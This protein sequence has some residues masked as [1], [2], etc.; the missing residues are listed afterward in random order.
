MTAYFTGDLHLGH[1]G[2]L[3]FAGRPWGTIEEHDAAIVENVNETVGRNDKLYIL[4]DFT[5]RF[6]ND[7]V[8][9]YLDAI[10]CKNRWLILGNH[11]KAG[12]LRAPGS[13][14]AVTPYLELRVNG[15][16]CCLSH[17]PMMDWNLAPIHNGVDVA[18]SAY[19]LHGHIHSKGRAYNEECAGQGIWRYDVGVDANDYKPVSF[20]EIDAFIQERSP[21]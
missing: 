7:D 10:K 20:D 5:F 16:L 21:Y 14:V 9:P 18:A 15:R 8:R 4:G 11:D 12:L 2:V 17:Y 3:E 6:M 1:T 13:F 19:M